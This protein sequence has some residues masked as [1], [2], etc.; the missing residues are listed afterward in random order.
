MNYIR[1]AK[2]SHPEVMSIL[3][4][5]D[6]LDTAESSIIAEETEKCQ[7]H[8]NFRFLGSKDDYMLNNETV[9]PS[10]NI[11]N[12]G[13]KHSQSITPTDP[14]E[15]DS[16]TFGNVL[17]SG[18][19]MELPELNS[20]MFSSTGTSEEEF[21]KFDSR[22]F[23]KSPSDPYFKIEKSPSL[24]E[25]DVDSDIKNEKKKLQ[26]SQFPLD[27]IDEEPIIEATEVKGNEVLI[28]ECASCFKPIESME[29]FCDGKYFHEHCLTCQKCHSNLTNSCVS[30]KGLY[31]C[32]KCIHGLTKCDVCNEV[33]SPKSKLV[34]MDT[35]NYHQD[36]Y[37]CNVCSKLTKPGSSIINEGN[38][39]CDKCFSA[40]PKCYKCNNPISDDY[41]F[42]NH[43]YFHIDHFRCE[44]CN[45]L[46]KGCNYIVHHG[47]FLC[48]NHGQIYRTSCDFCKVSINVEEKQLLWH[49]KLYHL[50]CFVCRVCGCAL[51]PQTTKSFHNRPHCCNCY[52]LR[53]ENEKQNGNKHVPMES[54]YRRQEFSRKG[55]E[56]IG[57]PTY[58]TRVEKIIELK[59]RPSKS[60]NNKNHKKKDDTMILDSF[61]PDISF[62]NV[63]M[64]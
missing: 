39:Y 27:V 29:L 6:Q 40:Q 8:K 10:T 25:F 37:R 3:I 52:K 35:R 9:R 50:D 64:P 34:H 7:N 28:R 1:H 24:T 26:P 23:F 20:Q 18:N 2:K 38:I 48:P 14:P 17:P 49:R 47:K 36:C 61:T 54:K 5:D 51:T 12:K 57:E 63:E 42:H 53:N 13:R 56:I 43:R 45:E 62:D 44:V 46:L 19:E 60:V 31:F 4:P 11:S 41:H 22:S 32:H 55:I 16:I 58:V 30:Y 33:I 21:S 15:L 59:S